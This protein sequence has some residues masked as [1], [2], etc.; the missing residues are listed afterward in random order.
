MHRLAFLLMMVG[1]AFF[2]SVQY[3]VLVVDGPDT[4]FY[5][6]PLP[7]N[8]RFIAGSLAKDIYVL[9]ALLDAVFFLFVGYWLWRWLAPRL[10]LLKPLAQRS[11]LVGIW[12]YGVCS[13]AGVFIS[14]IALDF[15]P[16]AWYD[17]PI[18]E[19]VSVHVST[20]L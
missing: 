17:L 19:V 12:V 7:W 4:E 15:F 9:P 18:A 13:V 10:S 14:I 11:V 5:G 8:S 20:C 2:P 3:R 1:L 16:S 6:F